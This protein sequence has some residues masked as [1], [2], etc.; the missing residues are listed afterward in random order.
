MARSADGLLIDPYGGQEDLAKRCLRHVSQ[1][2]SEDP[3][4]VLRAARFYARFHHF[5]FDIA[6]STFALMQKLSASG[7]LLALAPDRLWVE[8]SK[9]LS[10]LAPHAFIECLY[11]CGA[12]ASL[13]PELDKQ[14]GSVDPLANA[15]QKI[16]QRILA[17]LKHAALQK[18]NIEERW[19]IV[20]HA[21][22]ADAL[23]AS[24]GPRNLLLNPP[25]SFEA[26]RTLDV[27]KRF[28]ATKQA[29]RIS[30]A[31]NG[32][33][34]SMLNADRLKPDYILQLLEGCDAF[35]ESSMLESVVRAAQS[36]NATDPDNPSGQMGAITLLFEAQRRC[37]ELDAKQYV[38]AGL[39]GE[40]IASA[41][42]DARKIIIKDLLA[43]KR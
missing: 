25:A 11:R 37:K 21:L 4:R 28:C 3:L 2:F 24:A 15:E 13:M 35:R 18:L 12:L 22:D 8:M 7:E 16:G 10:E 40:E 14:F 19:G 9:G 1:A 39:K 36:I 43:E 33:L 38:D 29:K 34:P 23:G 6:E 17:A 42:R 32:L 20:C 26:P 5:G 41:M 31:L 27:C 30:L